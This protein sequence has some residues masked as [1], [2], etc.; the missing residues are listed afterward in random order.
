MPDAVVAVVRK[1]ERRERLYSKLGR[2]RQRPE[3]GC[4]AGGLEV[5][6]H[7][8]REHVGR[9][10]DVEAAGEDGARDAVEG[11]AVPGYLRPVDGEMWGD[12]PVEALLDEDVGGGLVDVLGE[13]AGR[14]HRLAGAAWQRSC[15]NRVWTKCVFVATAA[16]AANL[17][18]A[19]L[20]G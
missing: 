14:G 1:W 12:G 10:K 17:E 11:R 9:A 5:P 19:V 8:G 20:A 2:H 4:D 15:T 3:R 13:L 16:G 6:A 18:R 7:H